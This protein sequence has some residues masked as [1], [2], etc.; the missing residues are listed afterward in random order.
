MKLF[1]S[2]A[3]VLSTA[4]AAKCCATPNS[5]ILCKFY[6]HSEPTTKKPEEKKTAWAEAQ[7]IIIYFT[8][9]MQWIFI[10]YVCGSP[11]W[12]I[13]NSTLGN[14]KNYKAALWKT[15]NYERRWY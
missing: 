11:S 7:K 14:E 3:V 4:G 12:N 13:C 6:L 2:E 5:K 10:S 8:I 15:N 9:M 1:G